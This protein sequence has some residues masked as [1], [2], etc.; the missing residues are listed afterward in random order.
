MVGAR[1]GLGGFI[2]CG[3]QVDVSPSKGDQQTGFL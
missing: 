3:H 1:A 2:A